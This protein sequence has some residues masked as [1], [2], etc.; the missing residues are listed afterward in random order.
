MGFNDFCVMMYWVI[1]Y[2]SGWYCV[3]VARRGRGRG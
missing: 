2:E 1:C 3:G